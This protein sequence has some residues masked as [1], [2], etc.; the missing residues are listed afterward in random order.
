M[1]NPG[2]PDNKKDVA[3]LHVLFTRYSGVGFGKNRQ[4]TKPD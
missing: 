1:G 4:R 3:S 2:N